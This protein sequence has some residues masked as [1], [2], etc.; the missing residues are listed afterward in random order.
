M[1]TKRL[2]YLGAALVGAAFLPASA[3]LLASSGQGTGAAQQPAIKADDG[4]PSPDDQVEALVREHEDGRRA[5][6]PRSPDLMKDRQKSQDVFK[7]LQKR[8]EDLN[9]R[10]L[11]LAERY[12]RTNAA[13][14]ALTWLVCNHRS[15]EPSPEVERARVIL[16]RDHVRSD[17]I[18]AVLAETSSVV[19]WGSPTTEDLLRR[20]LERS[21]YVE[22][23][24][25]ACYRL[26]E[27]LVERADRVRIWQLLGSPPRGDNR[28]L[29][30]GPEQVAL[31]AKS[32]PRGLEDEAA[33]LLERMI[34]E[35]PRVFENHNGKNSMGTHLVPPAKAELDRLRRLSVGKPAPE[36]TGV[37]LDGKPMK[38]SE[39]RGKVVVLYFGPYIAFFGER[40]A[41][42]VADRFRKLSTAFAG[43]PFAIVGVVTWQ[44]DDYR[45]EFRAGGL[46][47]RFW[48]DQATRENLAGRIHA[49][50]D[51]TR[52][53]ADDAYYVLDPRGTIRYHLPGDP[54]L[55]EK[56]VTKLLEEP[57]PAGRAG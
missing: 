27:L 15:F 11:A 38:L 55:I 7:E 42:L 46:P 20:V 8:H 51:L 12:P 33:L 36:I 37:D 30:G 43:K 31:M 4:Q 26:A 32:D 22:I 52:P 29:Q 35:F 56:A 41:S 39:Y 9:K 23:R 19:S 21:P 16:A 24:G 17:R 49:A 6:L 34:A 25:L 1:S 53:N 28:R 18:K 47:V 5:L 13:E 40:T 14:Q 45:K 2:R 57:E 48:A 10:F 3:G 54:A 50:W 44:L